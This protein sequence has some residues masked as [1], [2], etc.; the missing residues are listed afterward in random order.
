[1]LQQVLQEVGLAQHNPSIDTMQCPRL[2]AIEELQ[3]IA[4]LASNLVTVTSTRTHGGQ[5]LVKKC[6]QIQHR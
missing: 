6:G 2:T 5:W 4:Q 1:M 3:K